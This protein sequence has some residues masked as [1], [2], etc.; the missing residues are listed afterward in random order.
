MKH[1]CNSTLSKQWKWET[2]SRYYSLTF[3]QDLFGNWTITKFWGGKYSKIHRHRKDYC[4]PDE[5]ERLVSQ[6]HKR[7]LI[8]G[9]SLV[10]R[11]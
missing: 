3:D 1:T 6:I 4:S 5:I 9:Y 7:R 8:R 11:V 10:N 2:T